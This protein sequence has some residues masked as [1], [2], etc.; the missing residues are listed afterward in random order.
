MGNETPKA[1]RGVSLGGAD[2]LPMAVGSGEGV[3]PP[4]QIMFRISSLKKRHF[5]AF[6]TLLNK[7]KLLKGTVV[8][9]IVAL[10]LTKL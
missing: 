6:Y 10:Q 2:P 4:P 5:R 9:M 7:P 3:A 1:S 8:A